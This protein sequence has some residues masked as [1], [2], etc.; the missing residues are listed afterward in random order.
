MAN[1]RVP[2]TIYRIRDTIDGQPVRDF[3]DAIADPSKL[4]T[5]DLIDDQDFD[6][7]LFVAKPNK[8]APTWLAFLEPGFGDLAEVSDSVTNSAVL[9]AKVKYYKDVFFA[10]T[11]GFGRNLLK[12]NAF[13]V[14]Y[15][16]R[17]ALNTL[18]TKSLLPG[19]AAARV[20]S[21]DTKT[22]GANTLHTR[23]Q[24]D[25]RTFF[26]DF[27][28]DTQRD[29]LKAVA[30]R[31]IDT[32]VWG[33][34]LSGGSTINV[35]L[36]LSIAELGDLLKQ[37]EKVWKSDDYKGQFA[38]IDNVTAVT[39]PE[40]RALLEA[41]LLTQLRSRSIAHLTLAPPELV[42]WDEIA[43]FRFSV[44]RAETRHDLE[45]DHYLD[46]LSG[47]NKLE[48][49]Q[50]SHLQRTHKVEALDSDNN[51]LHIWSLFGCISGEL[52]L[53]GKTYLVSEG[54]FFE[55]EENYRRALDSYVANLRE[56]TRSLPTTTADT[57]EGEYND[58]AA[59]G[60]PNYLLLD[61]RTVKL[62]TRTSPI[63]ICDILSEDRCFI[64]VKRKLASSS[65]SHLFSQGYVS[66]DLFHMSQAYREA[67]RSEV[68]AAEQDREKVK[69]PGEPSFIDRFCTFSTAGITPSEYEIT[70]AIIA[71]W[72]GRALVDALPF[73]SK[74]NLRRHSEDLR[75][76]G[77]KVTYKRIQ[78]N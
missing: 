32:T 23:R 74:V 24:M 33:S 17:F 56:C 66:G 3:D 34:R 58:T 51:L 20:R 19:E 75:R 31:P 16:L 14:N 22:V 44:K 6:A 43:S 62:S 49:L 27:G 12:R 40:L 36:S 53:A 59:H 64:H 4:A 28:I 10:I 5:Y 48:D 18:Y 26:E 52:K 29:L 25:S 1:K 7:R 77:Y 39:D 72:G 68:K 54:D 73:F 55:V 65:L 42:E 78:A 41:Q 21:V 47:G 38:W 67:T 9:V 45:L 30:G 61:K 35:S 13:K 76:L 50:M 57:T 8:K 69:K 71:D 37:I 2:L 11:F 63:E 60:S 70:Y 46:L 15:G